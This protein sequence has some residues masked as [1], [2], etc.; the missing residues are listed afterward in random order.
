MFSLLL[1]T[2]ALA[3]HVVVDA[4]PLKLEVCTDESAQLFYVVDQ[5]SQWSLYC[6]PHFRDSLGPFDAKDESLLKQHSE[7]RKARGWGALDGVMLGSDDWKVALRDAQ[8]RGLL[9]A[10]EAATEREVLSHFATKLKPFLDQTRTRVDA[11]RDALP[12]H[13]QQ[14]TEFATKAARFTEQQQLTVSALFVA[15]PKKNNGERL[16]DA[17]DAKIAEVGLLY[18]ALLHGGGA[19]ERNAHSEQHRAFHLRARAI[20]VDDFSGVGHDPGF[21]ASPSVRP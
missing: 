13:T 20:E 4:G 11:A 18:R 21:A 12:A 6:H 3:P 1:T 14:L 9:S 16:G 7:I 2:L 17:C 8:R 10:K 5:I 15:S 19:V